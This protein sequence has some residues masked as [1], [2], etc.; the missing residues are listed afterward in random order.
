M[1]SFRNY[2]G[3]QFRTEI[4]VFVW[5]KSDTGGLGRTVLCTHQSFL[6]YIVSVSSIKTLS[7][8]I[9][10]FDTDTHFEHLKSLLQ[11]TVLHPGIHF[12]NYWNVKCF[13]EIMPF[14]MHFNPWKTVFFIISAHFKETVPW[15]FY[16]F[17]SPFG[18]NLA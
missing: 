11:L 3:F 13:I 18:I 7:W 12:E 14:K 16:R 8:N 1:D 15:D 10:K 2:N 6:A 9:V 5:W 17:F 4:V